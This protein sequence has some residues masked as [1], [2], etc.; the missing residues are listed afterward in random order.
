MVGGEGA[1]QEGDQGRRRGA[2]GEREEQG[3]RVGGLNCVCLKL[4]S[5]RVVGGVFEGGVC[6]GEGGGRLI[7]CQCTVY[8]VKF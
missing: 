6:R 3:E 7:A 2:R 8:I 5:V 1:G 4:V